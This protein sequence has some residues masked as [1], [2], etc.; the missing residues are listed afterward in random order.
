M[1]TQTD[2][3]HNRIHRLNLRVSLALRIMT[4]LCL[5]LMA[6]GLVMYLL[7]GTP[8]TVEL[9][10]LPQLISHLLAFSPATLVTAGLAIA[11]LM[12]L[13]ILIA[14]FIHFIINREKNPIIICIVLFAMLIS[15]LV[16]VAISR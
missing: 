4:M 8:K 13:M 7:T 2:K 9:M 10:P 3:G 12:P 14:S 15:S 11:L 16:L 6:A 5:L 1:A